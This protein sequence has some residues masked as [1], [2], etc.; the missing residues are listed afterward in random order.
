MLCW[1]TVGLLSLIG[2]AFLSAGGALLDEFFETFLSALLL[3]VASS[4]TIG[5]FFLFEDIGGL[6]SARLLA[7]ADSGPP[8]FLEG[9]VLSK[10]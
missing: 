3:A 7:L 5:F 4:T 9:E 2:T 8:S 6:A 1:G 10:L